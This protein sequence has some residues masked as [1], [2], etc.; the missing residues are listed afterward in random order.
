MSR[1]VSRCA[2]GRS[3]AGSV[4]SKNA[5]TAGSA[6]ARVWSSAWAVNRMI[7]APGASSLSSG[8]ASRPVSDPARP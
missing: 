5:S 6:V 7:F 1:P 3:R 4:L 8:A 2:K